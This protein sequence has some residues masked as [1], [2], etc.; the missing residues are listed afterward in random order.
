MAYGQKSPNGNYIPYHHP[1]FNDE[2]KKFFDDMI[3]LDD[4]AKYLEKIEFGKERSIGI[5][6]ILHR[7]PGSENKEAIIEFM[8][9]EKGSID[10]WE[11][12]TTSPKNKEIMAKYIM[13]DSVAFALLQSHNSGRLTRDKES[14]MEAAANYPYVFEKYGQ[15]AQNYGKFENKVAS[16][17]TLDLLLALDKDHV[18][19]DLKNISGLIREGMTSWDIKNIFDS[20]Y[21]KDRDTREKL[22]AGVLDAK[23]TLDK[24]RFGSF[25]NSLTIA[26][27]DKY[28]YDEAKKE[29]VSVDESKR[30]ERVASVFADFGVKYE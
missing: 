5:L 11:V 12:N 19:E 28:F 18:K 16:S 26:A 4:D 14:I 1:E 21:S 25:V 13:N 8:N 23:K 29:L 24:D 7:Y 3:A 20:E 9:Q 27:K 15:A 22:F 17:D 6:K 2:F 30:P 10:K